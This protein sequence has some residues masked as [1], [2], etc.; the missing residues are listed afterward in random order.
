MKLNRKFASLALSIVFITSAAAFGATK[1]ACSLV[2]AADA[3]AVLG[4]PVGPGVPTGRSGAESEGSACRFKSTQTRTKSVSLTVEYSHEDLNG[5]MGA[6][7]EN[8]KQSGFK[9]VQT[10]SGAGDEAIW[11]TNTMLG[12][13]MGE[14]TVRKGKQIMLIIIVN[15][16][17]DEAAALTRAKAL[18]NLALHRI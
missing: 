9:N 18:A 12:R 7:A 3:Q 17:A 4:E 10:V 1:D 6:M 14:L 13:S 2:T 15:G 16:V 8:L 11:A 5:K